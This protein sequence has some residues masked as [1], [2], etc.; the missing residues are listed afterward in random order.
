MYIEV[1]GNR[2]K[3]AP[4]IFTDLIRIGN[5]FDGGY[6]VPRCSIDG[7]G[8]LVSFGVGSNWTFESCIEELLPTI[9]IYGF[10]HTVSLAYFHKKIVN[11]FVKGLIRRDFSKHLQP[12]LN[13]LLKY[14][15]FWILNRN[16]THLQI[17]ITNHNVLKLLKKYTRNSGF[18]VKIDIEGGEFEILPRI[19][20]YLQRANFLLIEFHDI[21]KNRENFD[22]ILNELLKFA[23]IAHMHCNNFDSI[24]LDGFPKTIELTFVNKRFATTNELRSALPLPGLDSPTAKNRE[25]FAIRF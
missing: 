6:V 12:R 19:F 3:L 11:G 10:D 17:Q 2:K 15:R 5:D 13:H 24:G 4:L 8:T 9:K 14:F 23:V 18:G 16:S 22:F 7:V 25:D 20:E 1:P 21:E